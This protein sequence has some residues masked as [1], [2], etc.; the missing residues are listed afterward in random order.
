[1]SD[2]PAAAPAKKGGGKSKLL[3]GAVVLL[4]AGGAAYW[5]MGRG[6]AAKAEEP[7]LETRGLLVFEPVLVNLSDG[8]GQRFVKATIQL[9]LETAH[10]AEALH[11]TPVVMSAI[12]S[13]MLELLAQQQSSVLVTPDG[14][15]E[16]KKQL[17]A[18]AE[19]HLKHTKVIDVLF[20]EF[21]VQF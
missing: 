19:S 2:T 16:L 20:S 14:K 4:L 1:M 18:R 7:G 3:I 13:S 9:V 11:K 6:E 15:T 8:G 17:K 10:D 5:F 21:V 12:R